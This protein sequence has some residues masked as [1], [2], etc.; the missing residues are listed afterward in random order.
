MNRRVADEDE[1]QAL[2]HRAPMV[3]LYFSTPDCM[4]CQALKPRV[5]ALLAG[6]FPHAEFAEVD[7]EA[8]PALAAQHQ[9]FS[10]PVILLFL[11][12]HESMRWVRTF[13][14]AELRDHL[15]RPYSL[16]FGEEA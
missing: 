6:E 12:G 11:Q 15:A 7:C 9:V 1:F 4:V 13:H 3:V 14:L 5:S 8:T 10:V 2:L 16:L